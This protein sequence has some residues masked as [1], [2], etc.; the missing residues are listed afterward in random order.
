[1]K[2]VYSHEYVC[3]LNNYFTRIPL[4]LELKTHGYA[5]CGTAKKGREI[6]FDLVT[7]REISKKQYSYESKAFTTIADQ[8]LCILWP[9]NNPVLFMTTAHTIEE[10]QL[11]YLEDIHRRKRIPISSVV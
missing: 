2:L 1:M 7:L 3:Y 6:Y 10:A 9:N 4:L 11:E 8:I 5:A